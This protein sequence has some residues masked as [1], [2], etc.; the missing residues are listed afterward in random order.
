MLWTSERASFGA[1]RAQIPP[2][3]QPAITAWWCR[4]LT[5]EGGAADNILVRTFCPNLFSGFELPRQQ[6]AVAQR[7]EAEIDVNADGHCAAVMKYVAAQWYFRV[8]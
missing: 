7:Q 6:I 4:G 3:G 2:R 8:E 5:R 1:D